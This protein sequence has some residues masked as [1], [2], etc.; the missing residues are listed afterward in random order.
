MQAANAVCP[1]LDLNLAPG[2]MDVGMVLV[3]FGEL[4]DVTGKV[5]CIFKIFEFEQLL[6]SATLYDLPSIG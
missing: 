1:Q 6:Q 4:A 5:Q 3:F 2:Q